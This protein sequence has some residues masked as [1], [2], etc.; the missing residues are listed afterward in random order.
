MTDVKQ[1][2]KVDEK[3]VVKE[4]AIN[5]D[6]VSPY[7]KFKQQYGQSNKKEKSNIG[8]G[9]TMEH[10]KMGNQSQSVDMRPLKTQQ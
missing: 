9:G 3:D 8:F 7:F 4:D 6:L 5:E 1:K 10:W 2:I